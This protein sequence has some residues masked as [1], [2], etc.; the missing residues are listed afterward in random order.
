MF[1]VP[2]L[3]PE[4]FQSLSHL[5]LNLIDFEEAYKRVRNADTPEDRWIDYHNCEVTREIWQDDYYLGMKKD[6]EWHGFSHGC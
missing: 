5:S 6:Q 4:I 2:K 1:A 3:P